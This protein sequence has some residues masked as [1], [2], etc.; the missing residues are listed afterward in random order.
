MMKY[1]LIF[2]IIFALSSLVIFQSQ[3][4]ATEHKSGQAEILFSQGLSAYFFGDYEEAISFF[5]LALRKDPNHIDSLINM[6][7]S[8]QALERYE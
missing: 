4:F 3:T 6:G 8:L 2:I 5:E 7:N 1:F